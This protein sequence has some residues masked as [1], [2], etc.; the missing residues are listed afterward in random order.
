MGIGNGHL[1]H[2]TQ[3][4][5]SITGDGE[6]LHGITNVKHGVAWHP[7]LWWGGCVGVPRTHNFDDNLG[8]G[9]FGRNAPSFPLV[10]T[11]TGLRVVIGSPTRVDEEALPS[12]R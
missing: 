5:H 8:I 10:I 9:M 12:F 2:R 3:L 7:F 1:E 4:L 11:T 6:T